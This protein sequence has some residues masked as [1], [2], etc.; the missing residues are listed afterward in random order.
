[1]IPAGTDPLRKCWSP[2]TIAL[3][4]TLLAFAVRASHLGAQ[5]L[6]RDEVDVIRFAGE[7]LDRLL[8][9]VTLPQHNGPLYYVLMRGWLAVAGDSEYG[10]RYVS[11]CA[12]V[13]SVPLVWRVARAWMGRRAALLAGLLAAVLAYLVWYA[14]DAKMYALVTALTLLALWCWQRALIGSNAWWYVGFVVTASLGLYIHLL[15]ALMVPVYAAMVA[16]RWPRCRG[17]VRGAGVSLALLT[18]PYLPLAVWQLPL[19]WNTHSTGHKFVPLDEMF[20]ILLGLNSRGMV[21]V[22]AWLPLVSFIFA[23]LL[24]LFG[25]PRGWGGAAWHARLFLATWAFLPIFLLYLI[26]LRVPLFEPRYL[27]FTTPPLLMLA[28]GGIYGLTKLSPVVGRVLL[29][30]VVAFNCLGIGVQAAFPIKSDFRTAAAFVAERYSDGEPIMFQVPYV[31]YV[32][33]Y[34]FRR[35]HPTLDGPWTNDGKDEAQAAQMMAVTA[36][37]HETLWLVSSESWLWD[38]RGLTRAWLEQH[39]ELADA[40]SFARVDVYRYHLRDSSLHPKQ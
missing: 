21:T 39:G 36:A 19:I 2:A 28:A 12:S 31:R 22:G 37:G 32:F 13:V 25:P 11:L 10:L 24:G 18:L 16:I 38:E 29:A 26:S 7:S 40:A 20:E 3:A 6:W 35:P 1:V 33:D 8:D 34:Y 14:Q 30:A 23:L 5:S 15:S 27:I 4:L 17:R 9:N